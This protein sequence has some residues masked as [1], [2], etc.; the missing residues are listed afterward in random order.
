MARLRI[1]D[2]PEAVGPSLNYYIP[3][4]MGGIT[5]RISAGLLLF[6]LSGDVPDDLDTLEKIAASLGGDPNLSET[7][8][9][10]LGQKAA[11][12]QVVRYEAVQSLTP[13][14][15]K[16]AR[17]NIGALVSSVAA[18]SADYT[19]VAADAGALISVDASAANRAIALPSLASVGD[20]F[21]VEIKKSD[22]SFNTVTITGTV[23][24]ATNKVLRLPQQSA[25]LVSDNTAGTWRVVAEAG[26]AYYGS[27]ANGHFVRHANGEQK[28]WAES[29]ASQDATQASGG[30]YRCSS[31]TTWTFPI[32]FITAP[33]TIGNQASGSTSWI[34]TS[35]ATANDSQ[36]RR[37][38][39]VS[40]A[41]V[42]DI[43][44]QAQGRWF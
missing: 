9:A 11:S 34:G 36:V 13:T 20:G 17:S 31:A 41:A 6:L 16:Q 44:A 33:P 21:P 5:E 19:V 12:N 39:A 27:N 7:I 18:K 10:A 32:G 29:V 14:Q 35:S 38:A 28:C 8:T 42:I 26:T 24:G 15:K 25:V 3:V 2:L 43:R 37:Y 1:G 4:E 40:D 30:V 22:T 23:D